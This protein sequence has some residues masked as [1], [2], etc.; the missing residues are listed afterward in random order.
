MGARPDSFAPGSR[1]AAHA[2][3]ICFDLL[4]VGG[5][6]ALG[7]RLR[8][9][10]DGTLLGL[11]LAFAWATYPWTVAVAAVSTND[12]LVPAMLVWALV[13]ASSRP[14]RGALL[15]LATAAKFFPL[16]MIPAFARRDGESATLRD[17]ALYGALVTVVISLAIVPYLPH[18]GGID[19]FLDLTV[20]QQVNRSSVLSIWGLHPSLDWLQTLVRVLTALLAVALFFVPRR[21]T[22]VTLAAAAAALIL[23]QELSLDHWYYLYAS[24][25]APFV[26]ITLFAPYPARVQ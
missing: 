2:A 5:L 25:F 12:G 20:R 6:V 19:Q 8:A 3:T 1:P 11:A 18:P 17:L 10:A 21:R 13:L 9:G 4:T 22:T 26:L 14:A 16:P 24:W 15:A 23:G 7:R